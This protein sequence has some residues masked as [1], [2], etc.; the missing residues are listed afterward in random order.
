M[1][2]FASAVSL[3]AGVAF[4]VPVCAQERAVQ[5]MTLS[6]LFDLARPLPSMR[7]PRRPHKHPESPPSPKASTSAPAH[8]SQS[9]A[10]AVVAPAPTCTSRSKT[11]KKD[12]PSTRPF[13]SVS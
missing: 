4:C 11:Q 9:Q 3:I 2:Y 7:H 13:F 8:P 10:T 5:A 6:T 1:A 12:E